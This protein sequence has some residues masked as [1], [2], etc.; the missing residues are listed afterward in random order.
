M[1]C[2]CWLLLLQVSYYPGDV[3]F[4]CADIILVNKANTAPKV[5]RFRAHGMNF[6]CT[7]LVPAAGGVSSPHNASWSPKCF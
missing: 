2:V 5:S 3:N 1:A 6:T 7:I 4:R